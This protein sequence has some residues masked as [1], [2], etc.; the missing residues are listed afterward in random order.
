MLVS[1]PGEGKKKPNI[2]K[3]AVSYAFPRMK[4]NVQQDHMIQKK[5]IGRERLG[6][7]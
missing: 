2:A 6:G 3:Y 7:P 5:E 4:D 1:V